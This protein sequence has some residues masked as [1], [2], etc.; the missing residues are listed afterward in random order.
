MLSL[1][2]ILIDGALLSVVMSI[3]VLVSLI[4]SPR[5][6]LGDYPE[7]IRKL[8]PPLNAEEKRIRALFMLP[9]LLA[10][11]MI[12]FFSTRAFVDSLGSEATFLSAFLHTFALLNIFNLFDA[13]VLDWLFIGL[14]HPKFALIP[15][16]HGQK[17]IL[18]DSRK[19]V[20]DWL[21]GVLIFCTTFALVIAGAA[22]VV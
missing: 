4:V 13:V 21:K 19:L 3:L 18:L 9:F 7:A 5:I 6:W 12:P 17:A 22:L 10:F 20:S 14:M 8:A 16:A 15:E 2:R 11:I 1:E